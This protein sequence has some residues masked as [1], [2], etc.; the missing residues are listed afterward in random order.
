MNNFKEKLKKIFTSRYTILTLMIIAVYVIYLIMTK[1]VPFGEKTILKSDLYQQYANFFC[2]YREIILNG[3]SVLMSW[4]LGLGNG[5]LTT[6]AYYLMSPLNLL[7]VFFNNENIYIFIELL[8]LIKLILIGNFM[9]LFLSKSYN[10]KK[11]DSIIFGLIYGFSSYVMCYGFHIMWL[12]AVYMLPIILIFV[13]KYVKN[14]K[15]YPYI[16]ALGYTILVNYYIGFMVAFFS[17][18]Y[19]LVK[20]FIN[21]KGKIFTI[22]NIKEL[23]KRLIKFLF[24]IG[25]SFGISMLLFIPSFIQSS[26]N[27]VTDKIPLLDIDIDKI[28]LFT[29][30]IFNNY[31]Y[32]FT[33]KSC[34]LFSSTLVVLLLP[35]Y[36]FNKNIKW[37]EKL[38]FSLV[39]IILLL[40]II[41][42]FLDK[43]W[44][45]FA[46]P[47]CFNY[48]Y[49][50]CLIMTLII[51]SFRAYQNKE[52]IKK[53][54]MIISL[55]LFAI[56]TIL[57]IIIK[58]QG[59]LTSDGYEI[60]YTSILLSCIIFILMWITLYAFLKAKKRKNLL[61]IL[62]ILIVFIDVLIGA[63]NSTINNDKYFSLEHVTQHD[64]AMKKL[65]E[66]VEN[67]ETDRII[68]IPD[69]YGSNM[70]LKYGYSNIGFFTSSR[71]RTTIENMYKLGYNIQRA[72]QLW[73]TSYSG[74][75]FNY[76]MAGV[77]YYITQSEL[78]ENEI[79]GF[80]LIDTV[81]DYYLY[82][83]VNSIP[84]GYYLKEN[85]M[86]ADNP[87]EMQ[88]KILSNMTNKENTQSYMQPIENNKDLLQCKKTVIVD[89]DEQIKWKYK[90]KAK[91]D[92][93]LYIYSDWELQL[94]KEGKEQFK[95]YADLWSIEAGIKGIKHLNENETY[96]F[97]ISVKKEDYKPEKI[98]YLYATDNNKIEEEIN[99]IRENDTNK[100]ELKKIES[101]TLDG[102]VTIGEDGYLCLPIA[103]DD[104]W[105]ATVNG[106]KVNVEGI[107][108]AFTGIK[109]EQ[110][111]YDIHLYFIPRG[112]K[113]GISL[114][115]LSILI[116]VITIF[117]ENK[118]YK[119]E[120]E[121]D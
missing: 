115:S 119:K 29:N 113:L 7:V 89:N 5:F 63:S 49:S 18:I 99:K 25:I 13:D 32:M 28:R 56:F 121:N 57:E 97:E 85:I 23:G 8:F 16:I 101:N 3:K 47:N 12:D 11:W 92:I 100:F 80:E 2:Y 17:G 37:K 22:E 90:I 67:K 96:E 9:M 45:G 79:Y 39:I 19:Y 70:S 103:Y 24:G 114:T 1:I 88:N 46:R 36:Y 48:R 43:M 64:N 76:S 107:Y 62:L 59:Y 84:F 44:H 33:Q 72:E 55:V 41:S 66:H 38:S 83:N 65:L 20:Y 69:N 104:G 10:Y 42:P 93:N 82:K 74:T 26:G 77:K 98:I 94:Y 106:Q 111:T 81:E 91:R 40:P 52:K 87:F 86:D 60:S 71:N 34:L 110:G 68:F 61:I 21:I 30:V 15:I 35:I 75:Y 51:M 105:R 4:N 78:E 118:K 54:H 73:I 53:F 6:F 58:M 50:F 112:F 116:L 102:T 31:N 95:K 27:I 117:I 108:N 14:G 120:E 109:L